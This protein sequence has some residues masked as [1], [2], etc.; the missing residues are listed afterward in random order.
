MRFR[1]GARLDPSQVT[2]V[3]GRPG[4]GTVLAGGGGLGLVGLVVFILYTVLS[5]SSGGLGPLSNLDGQS[6]STGPPSGALAQDCQTGQDANSRRTA[7]SSP[8]STSVQK[9]WAGTIKRLHAREDGLLYRCAADRLRR[10]QLAGGALLLP[11]RRAGVHRPRVL[12]RAAVAVR[13]AGR[14][15][16]RGVRHRARVRPPR[17]GPA[18]HAR[19][20]RSRDSG[21][22]GGSVRLELQADCYAGRVGD[23][24]R[25]HRPDRRAHRRPTSPPGSTPRRAVGDDRIQQSTRAGRTPRR[26]RTARREQRGAGSRRATKLATRPLATP[27]PARSSSAQARLSGR[28]PDREV[29]RPREQYRGKNPC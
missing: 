1:P 16:R 5:G 15:L 3:R 8:T 28:V 20:V 2:D 7:A 27:S 4:G 17:T 13:R 14:P 10:R 18:R 6:V 25:R 21:P 26:G 12:R 29:G 22:E 23:A 11:A 24:R 9:Y 19:R